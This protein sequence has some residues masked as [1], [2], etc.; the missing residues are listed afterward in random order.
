MYLVLK[1]TPVVPLGEILCFSIQAIA[2]PS[3]PPPI[4]NQAS[5]IVRAR[6]RSLMFSHSCLPNLLLSHLV[7]LWAELCGSWAIPAAA[8]IQSGPKTV[9]WGTPEQG[10]E[11]KP[12]TAV[13]AWGHESQTTAGNSVSAAPT[14]RA[15]FTTARLH[16]HTERWA[17]PC[18]PTDKITLR[19]FPSDLRG[20]EFQCPSHGLIRL[21]AMLLFSDQ[22][23]SDD[24]SLSDSALLD[25][26]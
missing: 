3:L 25:E 24:S 8:D 5:F 23:T 14:A 19:S 13:Q 6:K 17:P 12:V 22:G 4:N 2:L 21:F 10:G 15:V 18:W 16:Q 1:A 9:L 26:G 20:M 7:E 11:E